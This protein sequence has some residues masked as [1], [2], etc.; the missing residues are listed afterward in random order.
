MVGPV[1][2]QGSCVSAW[3]FA[4]AEVVKIRHAI[5]T[6]IFL[7]DLSPQQL[8]DC[9]SSMA[10]VC[11]YNYHFELISSQVT[12][13]TLDVGGGALRTQPFSMFNVTV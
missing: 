4:V 11:I 12:H 7:P 6:G 8:V 3:A 5:K 2:N 13:Q 9:K 1:K 10:K